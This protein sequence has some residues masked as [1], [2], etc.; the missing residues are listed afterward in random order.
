VL[1]VIGK[2]A[3]AKLFKIYLSV[4]HMVSKLMLKCF[5]II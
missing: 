2:V 1:V 3:Q 5:F 4:M